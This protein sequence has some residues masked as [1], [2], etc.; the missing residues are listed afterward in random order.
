MADGVGG[1]DVQAHEHELAAKADAERMLKA[2][3]RQKKLKKEEDEKWQE[4]SDRV[5]HHPASPSLTTRLLGAQKQA[6]RDAE[7]ARERDAAKEE[8]T[9]H[10]AEERGH[11]SKLTGPELVAAK[12]SHGREV[13]SRGAWGPQPRTT[14][15]RLAQAAEKKEALQKHLAEEKEKAEEAEQKHRLRRAAE[16]SVK[17]GE[18][19]LKDKLTDEEGQKK[20]L[21]DHVRAWCVFV[22]P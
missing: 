12:E 20:E 14:R 16:A 8:Q 11:K 6:K 22:R 9:K 1:G 10:D 21:N 15:P 2:E 7:I 19:Q 5:R 13:R 18:E 17:A 4:A 3:Q